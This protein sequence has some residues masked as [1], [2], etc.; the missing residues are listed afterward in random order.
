MV[1]KTP[2]THLVDLLHWHGD[3]RAART[4]F[5][6]ESDAGA[7]TLWTY[8]EVDR[9]ARSV[10]V[11]LQGQRVR[12]GDRVL[13]LCPAGPEFLAGFLGSLYAGAVP[14][15]A[16]PPA[17]AKHIGR[18]E[19]I[20]R[21]AEATLIATTARTRD[22]L[23]KWLHAEGAR[24]R[25]QFLCVDQI[26]P[27]RAVDWRMPD[28]RPESL[29][30]LQYTSGS[31]SEP[32][33]VMVSHGNLMANLAMIAHAMAYDDQAS[34]VSWLPMF[35]DMG[36]IGNVLEQLYVGARTTLISPQSFVQ[37]PA[38][39]LHL[40]TKH[41]ATHTGAPNFG[42]ALAV[43]RVSEDQRAGLDLSALRVTYCGSE[44]IDARVVRAFIDTYRPF[45]FPAGSFHACYGMAEAT[46]MSTGNIV[47]GGSP[48]LLVEAD[49][50][51][52]G[53][54]VASDAPTARAL[55]GCGHSVQHQELRIVDPDTRREQADG[56]V[57]SLIHI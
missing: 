8:G 7:E 13:L 16:Y 55:V 32:R 19:L 46:L 52:H 30:F 18:V 25:F 53:R 57:L 38:R 14:V 10:A 45:G 54:A 44:P 50:I 11:A 1:S 5:T 4:A 29:A 21:D 40:L 41:R 37:S 42:F 24:P 43:D 15:P 34:M 47:G 3:T 17:S 6:F 48:V 27:L 31:T 22:R 12:P 39:W 28:L 20:L 33:G 56:E 35:H 26:D 51:A 9:Q 2:R 23:D 36:L 49:A